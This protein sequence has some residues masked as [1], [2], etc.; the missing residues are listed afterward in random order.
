MRSRAECKRVPSRPPTTAPRRPLPFRY[1][2]RPPDE[3]LVGPR[4]RR[5]ATAA[6]AGQRPPLA[7]QIVDQA[8]AVVVD[9]VRP[10]RRARI[11][12]RVRVV[13]IQA[14]TRGRLR[15]AAMPLFAP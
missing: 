14:A 7:V 4:S 8:V 2:R 3:G 6:G 12:V 11:A 13:S 15:P 1:R 5:G 9:L 10:L